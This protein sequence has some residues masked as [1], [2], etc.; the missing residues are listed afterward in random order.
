[1]IKYVVYDGYV[2]SIYDG[3]RHYI[4]PVEVAKLYKVNIGE[5]IL[6]SGDRDSLVNRWLLSDIDFTKVIKLYPDIT[7]K[8]ELPVIEGKILS[9]VTKRVLIV[10][11]ADKVNHLT[12][13]S[14]GFIINTHNL[15]GDLW[16]IELIEPVGD[17]KGVKTND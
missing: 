11:G 4:H 17:Y 12:H 7:G 9:D 6:I 16:S 15:N 5:C 2:N 3:Q 8:Y 14:K 10:K 13:T 1:M